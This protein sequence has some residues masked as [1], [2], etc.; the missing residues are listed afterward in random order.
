MAINRKPTQANVKVSSNVESF[1]EQGGSVPK[2]AKKDKMKDIQYTQL[3]LT[4]EEVELIDKAREGRRPKP[5]RHAWILE[6]IY[7]KVDK[8]TLK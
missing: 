4:A 6:A 7:D 2:K 3:R 5:S 8:E 1:I